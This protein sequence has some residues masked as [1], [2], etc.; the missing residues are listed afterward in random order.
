MTVVAVHQV[1]VTLIGG[2]LGSGKTTFINRLLANA[3]GHR[4]AVLVNDLGAVNIDATLI[5]AHD[6]TTIQLTNGCVCCGVGDDIGAA[7]AT[8]GASPT[9]FDRV[10]ME[11][12][13][14]AEPGRVAPW[15]ATPGFQLDGIVVLADAER[16]LALLVD[17]FVGDSVVAQLVSADLVLVT[18]TDLVDAERLSATLAAIASVT[19]AQPAHDPTGEH[20]VSERPALH[21]AEVVDLGRPT[22][23]GLQRVIAGLPSDVIRA[24]GLIACSDLIHPVEVQVVGER[25]ELTVRD[26]L[27]SSA[28]PTSLVVIRRDTID[29]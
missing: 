11:L 17:R 20:G 26:D 21:R 6:G 9:P 27:P 14:V 28:N 18:K 24:K 15:A 7:L 5:A 25:R 22:L 19:N 23:A 12:S 3:D 13:G 16:I 2:Y 4:L 10:V 1:P 29:S 8:V